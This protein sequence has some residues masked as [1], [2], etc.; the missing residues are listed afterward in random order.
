MPTRH[1]RRPALERWA[2]E[3]E[4][5]GTV[6]A[7]VGRTRAQVEGRIDTVGVVAASQ[8]C[9][10]AAIL[11]TYRCTIRCRHCL[12]GCGGDRPD[13]VMTPRHCADGLA[14]LHDTGR[15]VHIAG[16]EAMMYWEE[17][18]E[19]LRLAQAEGVAPHFLETNCSFARDEGVARQRLEGLAELGVRGLLA[20][21]DAYHQEFVPAQRFVRVRRL[22]REIWGAENFYGPGAPDEEIHELEAIASDEERQR[23]HARSHPPNM[24][25]TAQR[26]LA[27]HQDQFAPTDAALPARGW[28]GRAA[29]DDCLDQFRAETLWEIHLDPYGNIQTNCGIILGQWPATTPARVL[30]AGPERANCFVEVAAREGALGLAKLARAEYGFEMPERVSQNCE[31]CYLA[32]RHLR[33]FHPDIFGPAEI[34][35]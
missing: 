9:H 17:L 2:P 31:L 11:F 23:Q 10:V 16:G 28:W 19:S 21:A 30:A 13:V 26:Q 32:R 34:Y 22:A 6:T 3:E 15:V 20:S 8:E 14:L 35:D 5:T 29:A 27:A 1:V 18:V 7:D 33:A 25:G 12:F 4:A 24:V